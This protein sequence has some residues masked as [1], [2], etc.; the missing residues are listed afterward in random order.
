MFLFRNFFYLCSTP[1]SNIEEFYGYQFFWQ[2][3]QAECA[4][5]YQELG[6][7]RVEKEITFHMA[8]K[9]QNGEDENCYSSIFSTLSR[10]SLSLLRKC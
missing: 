9:A 5:F 10:P 6:E 2:L 3:Q 8:P 1:C 4:G 7:V